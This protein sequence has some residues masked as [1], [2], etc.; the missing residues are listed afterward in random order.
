MNSKHFRQWVELQTAGNG[1]LA[2]VQFGA[3]CHVSNCVRR[4]GFWLAKR[5]LGGLAPILLSIFLVVML[6]LPLG[7]TSLHAQ[8]F[9]G[10]G[11]FT[12]PMRR[13]PYQKA[14]I[15][16]LLSPTRSVA[17]ARSESEYP[18]KAGIIGG[19]Q[20]IAEQITP[21]IA[22]LARALENDPKKIFDFVHDQIR[23]VH[24]FGSKKG[25]QL[26]LLERSG[27]DFDQCALLV[28]LLRAAGF[29]NV[30]YCFGFAGFEYSNALNQ[31]LKHWLC[32]Q[33]P[34]WDVV[35]GLDTAEAL[36]YGRG[37]PYVEVYYDYGLLGIHHILVRL[38]VGTNTYWLDPA[39][40]T[41]YKIPGVTNLSVWAGITSN[42]LYSVNASASNNDYVQGLNEADLHAKL[43]R[44]TSNLVAAI[45]S[46]CP[47]ATVAEVLGDWEVDTSLWDELPDDLGRLGYVLVE[48]QFWAYI[49]TNLMSR[50]CINVDGSNR[51]LY[52]PELK[53]QL[54]ALTFQSNGLAEL[55]L[56]D[57]VL[58]QKQTS[59]GRTVKVGFYVDH[60]H[61]DWDWENNTLINRDWNDHAATNAYQRTNAT[62]VICYAFDPHRDWLEWRQRKLDEYRA[63]GLADDSRQ[64]LTETLNIM[65]LSWMLQTDLMERILA[66]RSSI[67][68][69][70][71]HRLGRMASERGAGYYVDVYMQLDFS[72]SGAGVEPGCELSEQKYFDI[73]TYFGSAMEHGLIEQLQS[74]N[75]TASS[76]VKM[77]QIANA[78]GQRVYLARSNNWS[79][80]QANIS[81]YDKTWLKTNFIDRGYS[82][83]L[84][85]SGTN[86]IAGPGSW[87]GYGIVAKGALGDWTDMQMLISGGYY[88]GYAAWP[89]VTPDPYYIYTWNYVAEP[90]YF[91]LTPVAFPELYITDPVNIANGCFEINATDLSLGG[92]EPRGIT[93]SRHYS[94][95]RRFH[96]L[97][98]MAN[99]WTHNYV[100]KATELS[101]PWP[102]LGT[103]T[104][105]QMAP[106]IAAVCAANELYSLEPNP[107]NWLLTALIAKWAVD[108]TISNAVSI[109]LGKDSL[110]F[111]KHPDGRF[112]PPAGVTHTLIK[113]NGGYWLLE[114]HGR[115]FK[116]D[117]SGLLTN[118]TDPYNQSLTITYDSSNRVQT[119]RDWKNRS[120]TFTY[121]GDKLTSVKDSA[122]RVVR[123]L[124]AT[125]GGRTYLSGV[126]D[127]ENKTN[128]FICSTNWLILATIDPMG[129]TVVS[130]VYDNAGH[131]IIQ[132][133]HGD[134][135][136]AW[137]IFWTGY[138]NV[139]KDPAGG[140]TRYIYDDKYRLKYHVDPLGNWSYYSYD[141]QDHLV[142]YITP[143]W[144]ITDY[145]YDGQHNLIAIW[146]PLEY[147]IY[148]EYD[149][150]NRRIRTID[151]RGYTNYFAYNAQHSLIA[152]TNAM[153]DWVRFEYN[154][155]GTLKYRI[156]PAGTNSYFYDSYGQLARIVYPANLGSEGFLRNALGDVLSHTNARGFVTQYQYNLRRQLTNT[157]APTNLIS[158]VIYDPAGN[159]L[160]TIDARGF[161]TTNIWSPTAKLLATILPPT[162]AGAS[163][164]SNIYDNRDWLLCTI[165]P[166]QYNYRTWYTNDPAGRPYSTTDPINRTTFFVHD[167]VGRL[168]RTTNA[169]LE[170][171]RQY[172]N[173]RGELIQSVDGAGRTVRYLYDG[174]GN[175][176]V[177]TNRN[178][179]TWQFQYDAANRL[180]NTISP[181]NRQWWQVWNTRGLLA[182][183]R[184]PS[185]QWTTNL[186]DALGRVTNVIDAMG[187]RRFFYDPN[188][189]LTNVVEG[190]RSNSWVYDAY[191]RVVWYRD[192]DGNIIQYRYDA[193]GNLTNLVYPGGRNVFY[194]YD[195]HNRLTNVTD[196][197]NR[198][199]SFEY[200]LAGRLTKITRP[201]GTVRHMQYDPAGQLTNILEVTASGEPIV[202]IKQGW[203]AAGRLNWEFTAPLQHDYTPPQR[204]MTYDADNRLATFNG[205]AVSH[206]LDG[207]MTYGPL[208]NNS[209]VGY[210]YDARNRLLA[211]GGLEYGY[212]PHGNRVALTNGATVSRFV[213]NPNAVLSQVLMR[214]RAGVTNY[215]VYGLGLLCEVT[216]TATNSYARYYHYDYRGSTVA[217][218]DH[219]SRVTDRFEYSAYG[220]LTYR[221]GN[222]DTPFLFN[223][224]YGVQTDPNGLLYMRARYYN[225]YICRFINPDPIGFAG[226]LNW[227]VY[228]DG[229]PVNYLDPFG[230]CAE[231]GGFFSWV[232]GFAQG[233]FVEGLW[234]TVSGLASAVWHI[235][236]T[237]AG[238]WNAVTHPLQT[239]DVL[240][241]ALAEYADAAFG[242]DPRAIGRGVFE[243]AA[244]AV[245]ASKLKCVDTVGDISRATRATQLAR[246]LGAAGERM[247]GI[248]GPKAKIP[249]LTGTA[250]Y[251]IPDELTTTYLREA[252]NVAELRVT[253]QLIDYGEFARRHNLT[254]ILDV[255]QTTVVGPKAQQFI[256]QYNVQLNRL[257]PAP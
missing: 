247:S 151:Q 71:H 95:A 147:W 54:L 76:T 142:Q 23:Y 96:N 221:T 12:V 204:V 148:H 153:G 242:G 69:G 159:V 219:E 198:K 123:Y 102:M 170:V 154:T 179:Y 189:N 7:Q 191:D 114:R 166:V 135:N 218:T 239:L 172:W 207:N 14:Q 233:L 83:L 8:E 26:T 80:V 46:N 40:K 33:T 4:L 15:N 250:N 99:G 180:T 29:T 127:P 226:G 5:G 216:E 237:A 85:A 164:I 133:T 157:I 171:T 72:I 168:I 163:V 177:L 243:L 36:C 87:R 48:T 113:T 146:D 125:N 188:G 11:W 112:I 132:Y 47:N 62:Y 199:T 196:W 195:S 107:K 246:E 105:Q 120:L 190:A 90:I 224:R 160:A 116:F 17:E 184:E 42:E 236:Q 245:P 139:E 209:L 65:G 52:M 9:Q 2:S 213:I 252:K 141:G 28:A 211:V 91:D 217:L 158:R 228:A 220:T 118:I 24:Y 165:N 169:A 124:Y 22:A 70:Y 108:Q 68:R 82:L 20:P 187:T 167:P 122:N 103:T 110:Q 183:V 81:G 10:P 73:S 129:R 106:M 94:S 181:L 35:S 61:G 201:N 257:Y 21:E 75:L 214:V 251:R 27:N 53:G 212:D 55:W 137:Y 210:N 119:I 66:S 93:F 244:M 57:T 41:Y 215:Y 115:T 230:L 101:V 178:G 186:Y 74:T 64:V 43:N 143:L 128:R 117:A 58:L 227:Y 78:L 32:L 136:K 229:N 89:Y 161:A 49:P 193:N 130:N 3:I 145:Y 150:Q 63:S 67:L 185:G 173:A 206:D 16:Y 19:T 223:G 6:A 31:D 84:P 45:Q 208:T 255:R 238:L 121:T 162:P 235:D 175:R 37:Y 254:F 111:V 241:L 134:T 225:P 202:W 152:Q 50:L 192:S 149:S 39:F 77:L 197:A 92:T 51:W 18:V 174:A 38:R 59:G 79:T 222:T 56:E 249:S 234:G 144:E 240:S 34:S 140:R 203:D 25:A 44:Y 232:G 248:T 104:P 86:S 256:Q 88:G 156:D 200:D 100:C 194:Y 138:E 109:T 131:V 1:A 126:I 155:D 30:D 182:A 13:L 98:S 205:Q 60:P 253:P 176:I 97:A 231:S